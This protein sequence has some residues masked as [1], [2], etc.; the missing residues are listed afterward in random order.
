[1]H[2]GGQAGSWQIWPRGPA[3]DG[4]FVAR[5]CRKHHRRSFCRA[6]ARLRQN[7]RVNSRPG[8]GCLKVLLLRLAPVS[9]PRWGAT[10]LL[11]YACPAHVPGCASVSP[12]C[13]TLPTL[14]REPGG[15]T[16]KSWDLVFAEVAEGWLPRGLGSSSQPPGAR[17]SRR[18]LKS[19]MTPRCRH[20]GRSR[21]PGK[22]KMPAGLCGYRRTNRTTQLPSALSAYLGS[23]S[24][25]PA[26]GDHV[27]RVSGL[28]WGPGHSRE[29]VGGG[30]GAGH[31]PHTVLW[32]PRAQPEP[33]A[34]H[35]CGIPAAPGRDNPLLCPA[36]G[37]VSQPG[38]GGGARLG[39]E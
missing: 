39:G 16:C 33:M 25:P 31:D 30:C 21:D 38:A 8:H 18:L 15:P 37:S 4:A 28:I 19:K 7:S 3:G 11:P 32:T 23:P 13:Q 12:S 10:P 35:P 5:G 9:E 14:L 29:G 24:H 1:M 22:Y 20:V 26:P 36:P 17:M 6:D 34:E 2:A 27:S